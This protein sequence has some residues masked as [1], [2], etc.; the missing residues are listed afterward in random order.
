MEP[1]RSSGGFHTTCT[2]FPIATLDLTDS[3]SSPTSP[4][5]C[6]IP[7]PGLAPSISITAGTSGVS[8]RVASQ[9]TKLTENVLITPVSSSFVH[10]SIG[11]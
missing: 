8:R 2:L 9:F 6:R 7:I 4:S 1:S 11:T 3:K 5:T 10:L